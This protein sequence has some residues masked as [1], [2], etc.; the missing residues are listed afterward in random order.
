MDGA[1][2]L[3]AAF[4]VQYAGE[5]LQSVT[6]VPGRASDWLP[7]ARPPYLPSMRS[8]LLTPVLVLAL[9]VDPATRQQEGCRDPD[10]S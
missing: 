4:Q 9:L 8:L 10:P 6:R 7:R 1:G 2:P 3:F 5:W